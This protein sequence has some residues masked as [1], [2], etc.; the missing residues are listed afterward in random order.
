MEFRVL[1]VQADSPVFPDT[2]A[3]VSVAGLAIPA[4]AYLVTPVSQESLVLAASLDSAVI[5]AYL[6]LAGGRVSAASPATAAAA[7]LATQ[8]RELA[9]IRDSAVF[10][11]LAG[12]RAYPV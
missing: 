5:R 12:I 8:V 11:A 9:A 2:A 1:A 10:R 7:Y 3:Q 4:A 6:D